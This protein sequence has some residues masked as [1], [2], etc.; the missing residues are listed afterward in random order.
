MNVLITDKIADEG[1]RVLSGFRGIE[2]ALEF[3]GND[4]LVQKIAE[5]EG[6]IV[7]SAT[8]VTAEVIDSAR[9][10]KVIGRAGAGV[11][12][13][14]VAAARRRRIVV[15]NTPGANAQAAAELAIGLMFAVA[16]HIAG[17]DASMK[18]GQWE[19]KALLGGELCGKTVGIIGCGNVGRRVGLALQAFGMTILGCDPYLPRDHI[20]DCGFEG[21]ALDDLFARSDFITLHAPKAP[22]TSALIDSAALARMKDGVH[23]IN[24]SRGGIIVEKDLLAAL[25]QG[26]VAAAGIDVYETEPPDCHELIGHPRVVATPHIGALTHEA[27]INVSVMIAE[28]VGQYLTTG[29]AANTV[30]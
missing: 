25:A 20:E 21:V 13:I 12:N 23:I 30:E 1:V 6:L 29:K 15:M 18:Q 28:Q 10:L 7:R 2:L 8:K 5:F 26:K 4:H 14:D 9:R 3:G 19:K 24:C 27:Q 16:R 11:D 22:E 17:A